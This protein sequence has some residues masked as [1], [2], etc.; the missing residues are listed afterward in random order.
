[1]HGFLVLSE[2]A[3]FSYKCTDLYHPETQFAVR[4]NDPDIAIDW[5]WDGDPKLSDK[6]REAPFLRDIPRERLPA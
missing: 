4:W 2:T 5:P 6:D 1:L 3:L